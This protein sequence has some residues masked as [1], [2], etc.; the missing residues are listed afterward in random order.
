M[1]FNIRV[2]VKVRGSHMLGLWYTMPVESALGVA[3]AS[4][5]EDVTLY[6]SLFVAPGD[7]VDFLYALGMLRLR[8]LQMTCIIQFV[9]NHRK[10]P[11]AKLR[12]V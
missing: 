6:T 10:Q 4:R 8:M 1:D 11:D 3:D 2:R 9:E 12:R 5:C 7:R